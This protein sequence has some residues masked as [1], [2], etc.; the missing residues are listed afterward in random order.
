MFRTYN[1]AA[2][3]RELTFFTRLNQ[4]FRSDLFWWYTFIGSWNGLSIL[5]NANSNSPAD[6]CI[7]AD[8]SGSW[9]CG[10]CWD[11]H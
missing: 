7:Q 5:C 2:K 1:T 3:L 8:A 6:F 11:H 9:G 4:E 10:A